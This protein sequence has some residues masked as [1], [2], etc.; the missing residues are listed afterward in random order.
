VH[1]LLER[2]AEGFGP[3]LFAQYAHDP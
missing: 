3:A 1:A 2:R